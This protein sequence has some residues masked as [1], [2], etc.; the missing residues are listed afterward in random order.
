MASLIAENAIL[1]A[2]LNNGSTT[3]G[4]V[5]VIQLKL[6]DINSS[7]DLTNAT[8]LSNLLAISQ[9]VRNVLLKSVYQTTITQKS[10]LSN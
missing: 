6:A 3:T 4:A 9:A 2:E 7:A 1:R 8:T 10:Q 5:R